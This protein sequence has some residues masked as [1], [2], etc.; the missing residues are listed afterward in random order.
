MS[1]FN[2]E[3]K[4][5]FRMIGFKTAL[6]GAAS[7]HSPYFSNQK[8][9]FFK[10]TVDNGKMAALRPLAESLYGYAAVAMNHDTAFYYAGVQS[11]RP[12]PDG[13]EEV[14]FPE[15]EYLVLSG[16]G[17]L[18]RLAFDKLEDQAFGTILTDTYEW[19][20]SGAPVAEILLNGNPADAEVEVWVPVKRRNEQ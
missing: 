4:A 3:R 8:T 5:S 19:E 18:S 11:S 9:S 1:N 2:I 16:G 10:S 13:A 14:W 6:T 7:V 20:Y 15:S 17:G 12:L